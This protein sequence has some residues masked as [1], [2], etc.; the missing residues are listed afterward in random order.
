MDA[1]QRLVKRYPGYAGL[2]AGSALAAF[3]YGSRAASAV[4]S[5][6]P[7]STPW[8]QRRSFAP[9]STMPKRP[10]TRRPYRARR[11]MS[12]FYNRGHFK[13][14]PWKSFVRCSNLSNVTIA[15]SG[16]F[17]GLVQN[18]ALQNVRTD[19]LLPSF[20]FYRIKKVVFKLW[21]RFDPGNSGLANNLQAH[22]IAACDAEGTTT[23]TNAQTVGAYPNYS[24]KILTASDVFKY[25]FYPKVT[26]TVDVG[27]TATAAG[28]YVVNPWLNMTATGITIPHKQ[29]V[30]A[31]S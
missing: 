2:A 18:V 25:T 12:K 6:P 26:N 3:K 11:A 17:I 10:M 19:D 24:S 30:L 27:G 16:S 1:I 31:I 9:A 4:R 13:V 14:N 8:S 23:P 7:F 22:A 5:D 20:R 28:S 29:L 21:P 15:A